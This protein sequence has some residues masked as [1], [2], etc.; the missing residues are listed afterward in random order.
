MCVVERSTRRSTTLLRCTENAL[1]IGDA[2]KVTKRFECVL[3]DG[4][5]WT[6][7][8]L[9]MAF[10]TFNRNVHFKIIVKILCQTFCDMH[11][12]KFEFLK[13]IEFK[14]DL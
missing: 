13:R 14:F 4:D 6:D 3:C 8:G 9:T 1:K 2:R 12:L 11:S 7:E 5:R 10:I